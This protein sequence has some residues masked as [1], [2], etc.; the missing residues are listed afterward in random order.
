[1][2]APKDQYK[3]PFIIEWGVFVCLIMP[4]ELK[5]APPTYQ[6]AI[7][8]AFKE[9]LGVFMKLFLD[10]FN[11]FSDLKTHMVKLRLCF[12]KCQEFGINFN[13]N[14]C[15]FLVFSGFIFNYIVFEE[16]KL[17]DPKITAIVNMSELKNPQGSSSF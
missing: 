7:N 13:L 17:L 1:M 5:N 12:D 15:I 14:K 16:G 8:M 10:D 6:R 2:I 11:I 9:Y 4:F 3:I